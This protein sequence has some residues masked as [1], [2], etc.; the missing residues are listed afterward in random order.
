MFYICSFGIECHMFY[1][2]SMKIC[3]VFYICSFGI[4]CHMFDENPF[5]LDM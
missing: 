2:W 3:N 1:K 4:A 5:S